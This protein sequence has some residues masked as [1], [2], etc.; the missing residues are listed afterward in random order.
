MYAILSNTQFDL[1]VLTPVVLLLFIA[2][3]I[4][5]ILAGLK[6][7]FIPVLVIEIII[8]I[9]LGSFKTN[10]LFAKNGEL[11]LLMEGLYVIGMAVLLFLSG[12]DTD[13]SSFKSIEKKE[14]RIRI[15]ALTTILLLSIIAFSIIASLF[16]CK[17]M[18]NNILGVILLTIVFS[19]TFASII[20]PLIHNEELYDT[21]IGKIIALYATK[22]EIL[23]I[24]TL[25][26]V[27]LVEGFVSKDNNPLLLI[28]IVIILILVYIFNRY[29]KI[30]RFK[31]ISGGIIHFSVR[32]IFSILLGLI[33]LCSIS[34]V[35]FILG[36]F[37]AGMVI[38]SAQPTKD[39]VHKLEIIGFGLFVPIFYILVGVKIGL[40]TPI[41]KIFKWESLSLIILLFII[42]IIIKIP[43]M[44]LL[45][46][47]KISTVIQTTIFVACTLI[48][49]ITIHEFGVFDE[50]FID[51]LIVASCLTCI[52]PP[53]IFNITKNYGRGK[54]ENDT[55]IINPN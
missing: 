50:E 8:G 44:Y 2:A 19:S 47:F 1:K 54:N 11:T 26:L 28:V 49:S 36:A 21:T 40:H 32:L 22:S 23:S 24:I 34:G 7:K 30:E 14:R 12:L 20:I 16:F 42:L 45:K 37:F 15:N 53:V 31:K 52:I 5:V 6:I 39:T 18:N 27:M 3:I 35:E 17:Y 9:L 25:S 41:Y 43:F 10:E 29:F 4:P 51:A 13:F 38:K 46:W 33:I 48:S 55:R